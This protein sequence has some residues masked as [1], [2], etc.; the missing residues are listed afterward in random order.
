[1]AMASSNHS[2]Y[3]IGWYLDQ[4]QQSN[5]NLSNELSALVESHGFTHLDRKTVHDTNIYSYRFK[6]AVLD[7]L[8]DGAGVR[9]WPSRSTELSLKQLQWS[10]K[11]DKKKIIELVI[12]LMYMK[13]SYRK[14]NHSN[15]IREAG[16]AHHTTTSSS[17]SKKKELSE[18]SIDKLAP[19]DGSAVHNVY[20]RAERRGEDL[21]TPTTLGS[22]AIQAPTSNKRLSDTL[23]YVQGESYHR[24]RAR[25]MLEKAKL[26]IVSC[27]SCTAAKIDCYMADG[28]D[29][30]AFC[31]SRGVRLSDCKPSQASEHASRQGGSTTFTPEDAFSHPEDVYWQ[32]PNLLDIATKALN[33]L[34]VPRRA[35]KNGRAR[36]SD[37]T[38]QQV[39]VAEPSKTP[40][41]SPIEPNS[42]VSGLSS[43]LPEEQP[44]DIDLVRTDN[45]AIEENLATPPHQDI[46]PEGPLS[47]TTIGSHVENDVN[48]FCSSDVAPKHESS[49]PKFQTIPGPHIKQE[50]NPP[51]IIFRFFF[52]SHS[53]FPPVEKPSSSHSTMDSFFDEAY[54][55]WNTVN[56][57]TVSEQSMIGVEVSWEQNGTAST[58]Q[59]REQSGYDLMMSRVKRAAPNT[60]GEVIVGVKCI[61]QMS[62]GEA[63]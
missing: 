58:I 9:F 53:K 13:A 5:S 38:A 41:T 59:W 54:K 12:P 35:Q 62:E 30:C 33:N 47:A 18:N 22:P 60:Y 61:S 10:V 63:E 51:D 39:G 49:C 45:D 50:V 6:E 1:M 32:F 42:P 2:K 3:D 40:G 34:E 23:Q 31:I 19:A 48:R 11:A 17:D 44:Q 8:R 36:T 25:K 20:S 26:A 46:K 7:Y 27:T 4:L 57:S 16:S 24:K 21:L 14:Q 15:T 56:L 52:A 28:R 55:V 37:I 29:I 43:T